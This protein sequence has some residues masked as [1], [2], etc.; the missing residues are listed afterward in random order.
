[1]CS[2]IILHGKLWI[3]SQLGIQVKSVQL[4]VLLPFVC[5]ST[6]F[7]SSVS[8]GDSGP[9]GDIHQLLYRLLWA[10]KVGGVMLW[11]D[12]SFKVVRMY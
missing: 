11:E 3:L 2:V 6:H 12:K 4:L 5:L 10:M 7:L 9:R 8:L 1:M